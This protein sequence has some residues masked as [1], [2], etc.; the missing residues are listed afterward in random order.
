VVIRKPYSGK[1]A[2][3]M[4]TF[5]IV[6]LG[7]FL[8]LSTNTIA[9]PPSSMELN[10]NFFTQKLNVTISHQ[11]ADPN[12]HYVESVEILKNDVEFITTDYTSQ[13]STSTYIY[14]Y[15]VAATDGDDLE[16]TAICSITGDITET[17]RVESPT[18]I[19]LEVNPTI[20]TIGK[21]T[22]QIFYISVSAGGQ[23]LDDVSFNIDVTYG[24]ILGPQRLSQGEYNF[25]YFA[26]DV[27]RDGLTETIDIE[28]TK[29]GYDDADFRMRFTIT[30]SG[31]SSETCPTLDGIIS[32]DEYEFSASFS[33]GKFVLH[34][35]V[36]NDTII[37][38]MEGKTTGWVAIGIEP[39]DKMKDADM[40]FG[41]V[42]DSGLADILDCY[43]TGPTGP[44]P[45]DTDLG[46][47]SDILCYGGTESAGITTIEFKRLLATGD[48]DFDQ[49]IPS[50]GE[51][52]VI[53]AL[54]PNDDFGAQHERSNNNRGYGKVDIGTGEFEEIEIPEFWIIHAALM[55]MGFILMIVGITIAKVFKKKKWWLKTHKR[56]GIL[57]AVF[58]VAGLV[59]AFIMVSLGSGEHFRV[60]HAFLGILAIIFA[61]LT[62]TLGF[63]QFK[64]KKNKAKIRFTHRWVGRIAA[65]LM[66]LN[67]ILGLILVGIL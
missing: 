3:K 27:T 50:N 30:E 23:S 66:L 28:A 48:E 35:R 63:M 41:W 51:I 47:T 6:L 10:Y 25:T 58:S 24:S 13:P 57:G 46:G 55:V 42:T 39:S 49:I 19:M 21:N 38:A 44:H 61:I 34:W 36:E 1:Y 37:I 7:A 43:S 2:R 64:I 40:I 4:L 62:P 32:P 15:D 20:D 14:I 9:H 54:G 53:W 16:V 56:I 12:N 17:I 18:Q 52:T 26:P 60:P 45:P 59:M 5:S 11:V 22:Q 65:V 67:I 29:D 31:G 8:L 33:A